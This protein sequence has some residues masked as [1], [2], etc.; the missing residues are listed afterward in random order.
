M[1]A[2]KVLVAVGFCVLAFVQ[3]AAAAPVTLMLV[4]TTILYND[5]P[6]G[7]PLPLARTQYDSGNVMFNG[8]KIGEYLEMK[9]VNAAGMNVAALTVTLF[10]RGAGDVPS[11]MTLEGVHSFSSGNQRGSIS[12]SDISGVVGVKFTGTPTSIT[13]LFP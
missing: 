9:D 7:A 12:A 8:Q 10:F 1:K 5:D 2:L 4:R 6:P 13:L 11:V 3:S